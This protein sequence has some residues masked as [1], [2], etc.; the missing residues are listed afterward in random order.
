MEKILRIWEKFLSKNNGSSIFEIKG[1][2]SVLLIKFIKILNK[3]WEDFGKF[4][5]FLGRKGKTVEW[6]RKTLRK[7]SNR[8]YIVK[9]QLFFFFFNY[10]IFSHCMKILKKFVR[11]FENFIFFKICTKLVKWGKIWRKFWGFENIFCPKTLGAV[12]A[13]LKFREVC[14]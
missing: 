9:V 6:I 12:F 7:L 11:N 13:K 8:W 5:G 4:S 3:I 10:P 1:W 14:Y 2:W